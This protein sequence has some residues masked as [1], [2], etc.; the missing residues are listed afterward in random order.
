ME[1]LFKIKPRFVIT[2]LE[3]QRVETKLPHET[4]DMDVPLILWPIKDTTVYKGQEAYFECGVDKQPNV[5]VKWY[6]DQ[7]EIRL[8]KRKYNFTVNFITGTIF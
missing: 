8:K 2:G 4:P 3:T 1:N 6:K 5:S 7:R